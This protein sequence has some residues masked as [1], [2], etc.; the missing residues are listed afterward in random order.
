LKMDVLD[1]DPTA[2]NMQGDAENHRITGTT[3]HGNI[4]FDI[5]A[6]SFIDKNLWQGGYVAGLRLPAHFKH[7]ISLYPWEEY[8][9]V[10]RLMTYVK[11]Y[12]FDSDDQGME[13][14]DALARLVNVCRETGPTLVHCQAGLNRS[15]LVV[16][17][18]LFLQGEQDGD[19]IVDYLRIARGTD[20]VLCNEAFEEEVRSWT[21]MK[22]WV[23][24][25]WSKS[26]PYVEDEDG[27]YLP[28]GPEQ[29]VMN[30]NG[31][32]RAYY[33]LKQAQRAL[34]NLSRDA[35]ILELDFSVQGAE[36]K[37]IDDDNS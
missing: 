9:T 15:S 20:A 28:S 18:A 6:W 16:A 17:R 36:G 33:E 14:V 8:K 1:K 25:G 32:P 10:G 31:R 11:L 34:P 24:V 23:T 13:Q 35:R 22:R 30:L 37:W 27:R 29:A 7:V 4:D 26:A 12:M 3:Y 2:I 5:P 21:H 19:D